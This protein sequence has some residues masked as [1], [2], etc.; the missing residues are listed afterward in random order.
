MCCVISL[1]GLNTLIMMKENEGI[2]ISIMGFSQGGGEILPIHLANYLKKEQYRV[3]VH[4]INKSVDENIRGLLH[5]DIPVFYTDRYWKLA[6]ILVTHHYRYVHTHCVASQLLVART[7]KRIPFLNIHHIATMHGGYEGMGEDK[8]NTLIKKVDQFVT[9]W[10]YVANNNLPALCK[11]GVSLK[12]IQ[13]VGNAVVRPKTIK[14]VDLRTYGIPTEAYVFTVIT[15]AVSKK[16]WKECIAAVKEA[17]KRTGKEIHLLLGGT[18]PVYEELKSGPL[19]PFV[20]LIGGV[21]NP[22]D[23]YAASY[24]G[25]LL[26]IRECA[27]L[28]LIEMYYA[29]KP[30]VATDTGDIA[31]MMQCDSDSTGI[32]VPL[33]NQGNISIRLSA[34]AISKMVVDKELYLKCSKAA[35]KKSD[36]YKIE[37]VARQYLQCYEQI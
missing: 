8:A 30:V 26:S 33:S 3:A 18:G 6:V 35:E 10:T 5:P 37:F 31:E 28:G 22:C 4:C 7:K 14:P 36:Q 27:P 32:L 1:E 15:R 25:L 34:E 20:H 11:A 24:C 2:L 17:R 12:K 21:T 19:D 29:G 16:C 23:Y 9:M 13:K